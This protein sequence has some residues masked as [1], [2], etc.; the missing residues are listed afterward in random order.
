M[1]LA[2]DKG[3]KTN[4]AIFS[5]ELSLSSVQWLAVITLCAVL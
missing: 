4:L 3:A 2:S 1:L 5:K